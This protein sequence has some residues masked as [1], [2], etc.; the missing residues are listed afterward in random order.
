VALR[1]EWD[2]KKNRTNIAKHGIRFEDA[3]QVFADPDLLLHRD[4]EVEGEERWHAI[5]YVR[6]ILSVTH[7]ARSANLYEV[8]QIIS[9]RRATKEERRV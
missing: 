1:F 5:G 2:S 4:R 9:A 7:T 3:A 8:I 6:G